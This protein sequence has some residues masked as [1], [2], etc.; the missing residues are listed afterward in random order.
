MKQNQY[1]CLEKYL[2]EADTE[3]FL[4]MNMKKT[5][6]HILIWYESKSFF[7]LLTSKTINELTYR[8]WSW[9]MWQMS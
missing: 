6:S 2:N 4:L 8:V 9:N 1:L 7:L 5:N 3:F